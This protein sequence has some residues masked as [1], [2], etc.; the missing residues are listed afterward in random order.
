MHRLSRSGSVVNW[1]PKIL[2]PAIPSIVGTPRLME[3][4]AKPFKPTGG[5]PML[6]YCIDF[7]RLGFQM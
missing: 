1:D 4:R 3:R 5:L 7:G 2:R 6:D